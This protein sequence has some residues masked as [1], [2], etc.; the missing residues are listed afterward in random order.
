[1]AVIDCISGKIDYE[2]VAGKLRKDRTARAVDEHIR[3]LRKIATEKSDDPE[4]S[5]KAASKSE[6]VGADV[7]NKNDNVMVLVTTKKQGGGNQM[8]EASD[9]HDNDFE[10]DGDEMSHEMP[11][12]KRTRGAGKGP[13]VEY[14]GDDVIGE[15]PVAKRTRGAGKVPAGTIDD[16]PVAK[17]TRQAGKAP[18]AKP[19]NKGPVKK[20]TTR[21]TS[22]KVVARKTSAGKSIGGSKA[23]TG[24]EVTGPTAADM[25]PLGVVNDVEEWVLDRQGHES[26]APMPPARYW[27]IQGNEI[28][29]LA[30]YDGI[31]Y[32]P[33]VKKT[34]QTTEE[35]C[36]T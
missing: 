31:L 7:G 16:A 32:G 29:D 2:K 36:G 34:R 26:E 35:E 25:G 17:R 14:E 20:P 19:V 1:M 18:V 30:N 10:E 28:T 8:I 27:D 22:S 21:A 24:A 6:D 11:V 33:P 9:G 15:L 5:T 13:D 4:S 12:A 3:K 23:E